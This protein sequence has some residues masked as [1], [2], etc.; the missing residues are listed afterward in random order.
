M[1][2]HTTEDQDRLLDSAEVAELAGLGTTWLANMRCAGK[3]PRY[4][5]HRGRV[6][7]RES[8]V[9]AWLAERRASAKGAAR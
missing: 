8:D 6:Y 3:G 4:I 1:I 7:Y 5:R 9:Q 2:M